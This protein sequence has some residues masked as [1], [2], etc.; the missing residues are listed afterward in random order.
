[1]FQTEI[2]SHH[3]VFQSTKVTVAVIR[4]LAP[5][6]AADPVHMIRCMKSLACSE[7]VETMKKQPCLWKRDYYGN[8]MQ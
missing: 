6:K 5:E 1:M 2:S 7:Q 4:T 3:F 8:V